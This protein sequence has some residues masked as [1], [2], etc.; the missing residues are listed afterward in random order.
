MKE[1][2]GRNVVSKSIGGILIRPA[3]QAVAGDVYRRY[4]IQKE[5]CGEEGVRAFTRNAEGHIRSRRSDWQ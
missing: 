1:T 3:V 5:V 4:R 2:D